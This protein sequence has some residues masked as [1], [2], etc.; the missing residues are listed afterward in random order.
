M[1]LRPPK[2]SV[3]KLIA[4]LIDKLDFGID[5]SGRPCAIRRQEDANPELFCLTDDAIKEL[6]VNEAKLNDMMLMSKQIDEVRG[7][8]QSVAESSGKLF[9]TAIRV[10]R[11]E[12]GGIEIDLGTGSREC[13]RLQDGKASVLSNGSDSIFYRPSTNRPLV[14]PAEEGNLPPFA[15]ISQHERYG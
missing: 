15:Q 6:I 12:G 13:V 7:E 10:S 11:T 9:K 2:E 8:L 1:Q 5:Q 14:F 4:T 3:D